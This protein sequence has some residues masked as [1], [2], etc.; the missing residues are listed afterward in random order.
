MFEY[1][2]TFFN[3]DSETKDPSKQR[4]IKIN[5]VLFFMSV[6]LTS[7]FMQVYVNVYDMVTLKVVEMTNC[8]QLTHSIL[9]FA[10][11]T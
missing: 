6:I 10:D 4:G 5:I 1:L 3:N 11:P 7:S 2:S 8:C 9:M